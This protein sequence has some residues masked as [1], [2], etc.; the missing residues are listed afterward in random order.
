MGESHLSQ[1]WQQLVPGLVG[2]SVHTDCVYLRELN[3][4]DPPL[5][6]SLDPRPRVSHLA[7]VLRGIDFESLTGSFKAG[8]RE[9]ADRLMLDAIEAVQAAGADFI[10]IT[11][12]TMNSLLDD[13]RE[14][15]R[16]PV[17]D[18][19]APVLAAAQARG[20]SRLG[21]IGT[22]HTVASGM[23]EGRAAAYG[24]EILRPSAEIA[25]AV[26]AIIFES[27]TRGIAG[28]A[29]ARVVREAVQWFADRGAEAVILGCTDITLLTELLSDTALPLLDSTVLHARAARQVALLGDLGAFAR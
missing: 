28:E 16:L 7:S 17:L 25:A 26:D 4:A 14:A 11:A 5:D 29:E 6:S 22:G 27:L 15:I 23:Y 18:I 10:V 24:C 1:Q 8:R 9:T 21:L 3:R 2:M 19:A 13:Y 20:F 12:N